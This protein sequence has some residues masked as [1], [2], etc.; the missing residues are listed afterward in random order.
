MSIVFSRHI[1]LGIALVFSL[2]GLTACG[3]VPAAVDLEVGGPIPDFELPSLAGG[4]LS[5]DDLV[6]KPVVLNFW[7]T[8]CRPCLKEIPDLRAIAKDTEVRVVSIALDEEGET[9]VRPFVERME[10]D[11]EV[12]LG[13]MELFQRFDGYAIPYT[14][15]LD[16]SAQVVSIYRGLVN[17]RRLEK[18]LR[19][20]RGESTT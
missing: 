4:E 9:V 12:L 5:R 18:D 16:A 20:A 1:L 13:D 10:I 6:G 8:W 15:V 2:F 17:Q 3:G 7:A 14:I 19:K 11:Y